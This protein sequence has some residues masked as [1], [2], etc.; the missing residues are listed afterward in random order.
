MH[1]RAHCTRLPHRPAC[2]LATTAVSR[3]CA[4]RPDTPA[5]GHLQ[6]RIERLGGHIVEHHGQRVQGV[7]AMTRA[8]GDHALR[9]YIICEPEVRQQGWLAGWLYVVDRIWGPAG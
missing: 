7:L 8:L 3:S 9:P 2:Q 6:E 4:A 1:W 5:A